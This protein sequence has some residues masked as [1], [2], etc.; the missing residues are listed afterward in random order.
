MAARNA[1][2]GARST[3]FAWQGYAQHYPEKG[4]DEQT[5]KIRAIEANVRTIIGDRQQAQPYLFEKRVMSDN[6]ET[7]SA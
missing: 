3:S 2:S 1:I 4:I 6:I 5:L 7:D